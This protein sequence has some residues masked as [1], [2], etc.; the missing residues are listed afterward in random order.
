MKLSCVTLRKRGELAGPGASHAR[1]G[2]ESLAEYTSRPRHQPLATPR[3]G[4]ARAADWLS[5]STRMLLLIVWVCSLTMVV[6]LAQ[7]TAAARPRIGLVLSGGGARGAAHVGVLKVLDD[8]QR[9]DRCDRR[10][11]HGR[12]R[13]RPVRLRH[14]RRRY[15]KARQLR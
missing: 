12:R 10:H 3:R 2:V 1:A 13:R 9:A 4:G 8:M 7:A 5:S 15:R 6:P 11:Q 14:E